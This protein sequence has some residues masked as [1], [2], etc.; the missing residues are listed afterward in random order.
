M[1][2][3]VQ[4]SYLLFQNI[5]QMEIIYILLVGAVAGWLGSLLFRGRG[6]GLIINV[7]LGILGAIV[8]EWIFEKLNIT[9][10]SGLGGTIITAAIGAFVILWIYRFFGGGRPR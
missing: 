6:S 10:S 5:L 1:G 2:S 9:I 8:G 4:F 3:P 7:L